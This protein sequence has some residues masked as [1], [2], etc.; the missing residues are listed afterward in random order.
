MFESVAWKNDRKSDQMDFLFLQKFFD[1]PKRS[2]C[3]NIMGKSLSGVRILYS[4]QQYDWNKV[5]IEI[6]RVSYKSILKYGPA[7]QQQKRELMNVEMG[8]NLNGLGAC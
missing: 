3:K 5:F 2:I 4:N 6:T 8:Y 7:D 1:R